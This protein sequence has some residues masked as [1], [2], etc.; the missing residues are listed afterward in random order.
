MKLIVIVGP[1]STGKT[2]LGIKLCREFNGEIV[3]A[4]SRQIYKHMNIG[5]GK[6]PLSEMQKSQVSMQ[7]QDGC[8]IV[9]GVYV[10]LYD[11]VE[12]D[13]KFSVARFK[14]AATKEIE[15]IWRRGKVPFLVGGTGFY[16][17]AVLGETEFARIPPDWELRKKL[18][19]LSVEELF[20]KLKRLDPERA[21]T[22]DPKNP[23]RLVRAI[24]IVKGVAAGPWPAREEARQGR[25][26]THP[27]KIG[28]TAPREILYQR[29]DAWAERIVNNG[30]L[31]EVQDL[32]NRGYKNAPPMQGIIYQSALDHLD[33]KIN[34]E[35]MLQRIKFDL[36]GYIRRQ[37][38]WFKRDRGVQWFD[39]SKP[40]FD[41]AVEEMIES[42]LRNG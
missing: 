41:V 18:E 42:F 35:E 16:I 22:I 25:A 14:D 13:R 12:P 9:D 11:V 19:K 31:E 39:V 6:R 15:S 10:H 3:S 27:L 26:A 36:H 32:V 21:K 30:L 8:W 37:L 17:A 40:N 23:R 5:T 34:K 33:N 20:E 2:S 1:T 38:T 28:L 24:E 7:K 29:A 4:D